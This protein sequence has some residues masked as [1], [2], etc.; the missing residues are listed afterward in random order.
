LSNIDGLRRREENVSF[1]HTDAT[2]A[3]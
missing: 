1:L 3:F 2:V